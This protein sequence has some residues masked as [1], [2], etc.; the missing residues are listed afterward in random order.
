VAA[1]EKE[2]WAARKAPVRLAAEERRKERREVLREE[3]DLW[4]AWDEGV[5]DGMGVR[6]AGGGVKGQ[7]E[8]RWIL[9]SGILA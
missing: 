8:R 7:Q 4:D 5:G 6:I 3:G 1:R 2:G 9:G